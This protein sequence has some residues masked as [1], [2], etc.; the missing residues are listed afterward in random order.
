MNNPVWVLP[1]V[2]IAFHQMLLAE[3]GGMPGIRDKALLDSALNRPQQLFAYSYELSMFDLAASY[4]YGLS[5]NH[6]F[7]D[8]NKRVA[9]T[10]AGLFLELNGYTFD[11]SE[12]ETALIFRQ[13]AAGDISEEHLSTWL[14]E[15]SMVSA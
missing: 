10:V 1:D 3:H 15:S 2:V 8:G 11:A 13:L 6:P 4:A 9:L 12:P 7:I 5:R 14:K